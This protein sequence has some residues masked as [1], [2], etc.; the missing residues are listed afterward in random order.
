MLIVLWVLFILYGT[1]LPF[2]FHSDAAEAARKF[3]AMLGSLGRPASRSDVVSNVLLFLPLG[4]LI[5]V[6]LAGRGVGLGR[7]LAIAAVGGLALSALVECAQLFLPGRDPSFVDLI[8][9]TTGTV[10]GALV[11]RPLSR[12]VSPSMTGALKAFAARRPMAACALAVGAGLFVAGLSPFDVSLDPGDLKASILRA[13]P[14]PFGSPMR[15]PTPPPEPWSWA[16]ETATWALAGG[17]AMLA[18]VEAGW[19]GRRAIPTAAV[20]CGMLGLV[21]EVSQIV[22]PGRTV[23]MTSV[24]LAFVGAAC[25]AAAVAGFPGRSPRDWVGPGLAVWGIVVALAAWTPPDLSS[26]AAWSL[27]PA[28]LVPFWAYYE[29]TDLFALADLFNQVLGF[30][31]LGVLL[32]A[33]GGRWSVRGAMVVGFGIGLVLEAGQVFLVD[34]TAEI[35]DALSASA[36]SAVGAWLCG[37]ATRTRGDEAGPRRYRVR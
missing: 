27:G 29:R 23:D 26:P 8:T 16:G 31:P 15:G 19:G 34:R 5:A 30:V 7:T 36:G 11:G 37:W 4:L 33:R 17:L 28:Q 25:G 14:V 20:L 10:L 13:R 9:N 2:R 1:L 24:L 18:L 21:I 35:T 6:R 32:A 12:L 3:E 22:I